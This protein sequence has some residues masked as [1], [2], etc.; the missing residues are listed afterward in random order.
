MLD[1]R[2]A[3]G[4]R[5][6]ERR[7]QSGDAGDLRPAPGNLSHDG[8]GGRPPADL[9][10]CDAIRLDQPPARTGEV[11]GVEVYSRGVHQ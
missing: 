6:T 11:T 3:A 8:T 5:Q 4:L 2:L 9:R 1:Q 10:R 7:R